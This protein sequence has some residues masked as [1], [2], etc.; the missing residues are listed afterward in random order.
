LEAPNLS[1]KVSNTKDE[2][3]TTKSAVGTILNIIP[4]VEKHG[5]SQLYA[6]FIFYVF[7]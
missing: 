7:Y 3:R 6:S 4:K 1:F 5:V 2:K